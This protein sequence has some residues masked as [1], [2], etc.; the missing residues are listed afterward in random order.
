MIDIEARGDA[1]VIAHGG[2]VPDGAAPTSIAFGK[3]ALILSRVGVDD[4]AADLQDFSGASVDELMV[5][6]GRSLGDRGMEALKA[7]GPDGILLNRIYNEQRIKDGD[8][9]SPVAAL[10]RGD[11]GVRTAKLAYGLVLRT[12]RY[13]RQPITRAGLAATALLPFELAMRFTGEELDSPA[14]HPLFTFPEEP[15][16]ADETGPILRPN[17]YEFDPVGGMRLARTMTRYIR[18]R[19]NAPSHIGCPLTLIEEYLQDLFRVAAERSVRQG[20]IATS[21]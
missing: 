11:S 21:D 4:V 12:L 16:T 1:L 13:Q 5:A 3:W 10:S 9:A 19:S 14:E 8:S 6:L 17:V 20:I 7:A 2:E 18:E 15:I